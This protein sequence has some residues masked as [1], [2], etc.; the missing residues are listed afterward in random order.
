MAR[1]LLHCLTGE[2]E[3]IEM[4]EE[5]VE[6]RPVRSALGLPTG[7]RDAGLHEAVPA[8]LCVKMAQ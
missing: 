8:A 2:G 3:R 6:A 4:Q 1:P 5:A 7:G